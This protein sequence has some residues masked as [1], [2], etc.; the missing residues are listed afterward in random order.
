MLVEQL[1]R[2][3]SEAESVSASSIV[4]TLFHLASC[5]TPLLLGV[6]SGYERRLDAADRLV[7]EQNAEWQRNRIPLYMVSPRRRGMRVIELVVLPTT[8][9]VGEESDANAIALPRTVEMPSN[10]RA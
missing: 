10:G 2:I 1:N 5:Y 7:D 9:A 3:Y 4:E 8:R 6:R